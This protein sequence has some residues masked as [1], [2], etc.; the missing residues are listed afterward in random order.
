MKI[1][2]FAFT[3][4]LLSSG[5]AAVLVAYNFGT[6]ATAVSLA[7]T[8]TSTGVTAG[9]IQSAG[10]LSAQNSGFNF[11]GSSGSQGIGLAKN[12]GGSHRAGQ[13]CGCG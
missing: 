9:N 3:A 6:S 12:H 1:H 5:H 13:P 4:A 7:A 10:A 2:L 11:T 8:T